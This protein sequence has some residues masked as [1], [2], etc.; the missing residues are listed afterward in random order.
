MSYPHLHWPKCSVCPVRE[1]LDCHAQRTGA[2]HTYCR[3]IRRG[4]QHARDLVI[5]HSDHFGGVTEVIA[6]P[7]PSESEPVTTPEPAPALPRA[8]KPRVALGQPHCIPCQ[9]AKQS[10]A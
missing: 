4:D 7:P 1:G 9:A 8:E 3:R 6:E 5:D 2:D 10:S